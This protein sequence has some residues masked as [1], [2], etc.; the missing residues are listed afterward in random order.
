MEKVYT[1]KNNSISGKLKTLPVK[2][3]TALRC[4]ALILAL[5]SVSALSA[6]AAARTFTGPGNFSDPT[7]WDGGVTVPSAG[8][9]LTINGACTFDNAASNVLYGALVVGSASAGTLS[10]PVS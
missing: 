9:A 8:D 5:W 6:D 2:A 1:V 7:K 4:L 3:F 10:W